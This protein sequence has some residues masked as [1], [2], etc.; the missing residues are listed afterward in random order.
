MDILILII[1]HPKESVG[2]SLISIKP[3]CII[4]KKQK[5]SQLTDQEKMILC[6]HSI[7]F[8]VYQLQRMLHKTIINQQTK[9]KYSKEKV[10]FKKTIIKLDLTKK[11][12]QFLNLTL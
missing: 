5:M 7:K 2:R 9:E 6:V 4:A 12:K 3:M 1:S 11:N 10:T 8:L